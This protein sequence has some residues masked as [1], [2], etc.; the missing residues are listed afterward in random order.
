MNIFNSL[1]SNYNDSFVKRALFT[2]NNPGDSDKLT[3]FLNQKYGGEVH[4]TYKGRD[5]LVM[6]LKASHLPPN[7]KVA[8]TGFTCVAVYL[9][10][11]EAGFV[12]LLLDVEGTSLNFTPKLLKEQLAGDSTIKAV[13]VQ[14]TLSYPC[15]IEEIERICHQYSCV[16]VEDAAH[17][18]G[19]IY[20]N[21]KEVGT[22][23]DVVALSFS[24]DKIIDGISGGALIIRNKALQRFSAEPTVARSWMQE[25]KDRLYPF[26][27]R[28]IRETYPHGFGVLAHIFLKTFRLLPRPVEATN[29]KYALSPFHAK[30]ILDSYDRLPNDI[31]H[32]QQIAQMYHHYLDKSIQSTWI[33]DHILTSANLRFPIFVE[34]RPKLVRY[35]KSR[36]VYVS[37]IWYDAPIGPK[38]THIVIP[39]SDPESIPNSQQIANTIL[40]LPTHKHVTSSD[41]VSIAQHINTWLKQNK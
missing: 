9:A 28:T 4:L 11:Q 2:K 36:G 15:D 17:C 23:G 16:L 5:A 1:G 19:T 14:N 25:T 8:I 13:I 30:L 32:R 26:F 21:G 18:I 22:I 10:V 3:S 27:T 40:N 35:L 37:D 20:E 39:G 34:N 38:S 33:T 7:A 31:K 41:A 12:P 29:K 6:A 24:Q